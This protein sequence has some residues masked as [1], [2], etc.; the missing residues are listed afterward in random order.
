VT[1]TVAERPASSPRELSEIR[2]TMAKAGLERVR[3][4]E[5]GPSDFRPVIGR[6]LGRALS[7]VGWSLKEAAAAI[8][9]DPRQVARWLSGAER[10]QLD[11]I[12][13]VEALQQPMVQALGELAG[14]DVEVTIR[15]RRSA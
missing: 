3:K 11:A 1:S 6:V 7:L 9:K 8:G 5:A 12:F 10:A 13:A 14:A 2:P 15:L 4:P